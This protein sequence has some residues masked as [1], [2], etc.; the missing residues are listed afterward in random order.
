MT[1]AGN[2]LKVNLFVVKVKKLTF[3][4]LGQSAIVSTGSRYLNSS[5]SMKTVDIPKVETGRDNSK[6][7]SYDLSKFCY[8]EIILS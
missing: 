6:A 3:L 4:C 8:D 2:T 7:I 5:G 1:N